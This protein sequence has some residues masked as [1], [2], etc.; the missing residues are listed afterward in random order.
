MAGTNTIRLRAVLDDKV[1]SGLA[2]IADN[3][4][5]LGGKGS[6]ASLF[7]N[8]GARAVAKGFDLIGQAAGRATDIIGDSIQAAAADEASQQRLATALSANVKAWD[9]NTAAIERVITARTKLGFADDDQRDS[10]ATL[11][12][13]THDV[14]KALELQRGAMD[15]ARARHVDLS[16]AS[17]AVAKAFAG[18]TKTLKALL[19]GLKMGAT[20]AETLA[21][22][23]AMANGQAEAFAE[24]NQGKLLKS[25]VA[26]N[27]AMEK[28]GYT[29]LPT[30]ADV[31]DLAARAASGFAAT[32]QMLNP[33]VHKT[34]EESD[35]LFQSMVDGLSGLGPFANWF[36]SV[37]VNIKNFGKEAEIAAVKA[38]MIDRASR[39]M[40]GNIADAVDSTAD[41]V[42]HDA[43]RI[44]DKLSGIP[45]EVV[46]NIRGARTEW[47]DAWDQFRDDLKHPMSEAAEIAKLQGILASKKLAEGL[48]SNDPLVKAE[49]EN[50]RDIARRRLNEL[51]G[52]AYLA[53]KRAGKGLVTGF[54]DGATGAGNVRLSVGFLQAASTRRSHSGRASGGP[55]HAGEAYTVGEDGPETLVMGDRGGYVYNA[56]QTAR[57]M[58]EGPSQPIVIPLYLDGK[59]IAEAIAPHRYREWQRAPAFIGRP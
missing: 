41:S 6:A 15:I 37:A 46:D 56:P 1:S 17:D 29:I 7:G 52:Q 55:V 22:A 54:V 12:G 2:K 32:L 8:V 3:F 43:D 59:K 51:Q 57:I 20:D 9:G 26:V 44:V 36:S 10:L 4:D 50:V 27:E 47:K 18:N 24:T 33:T 21:N 42:A 39:V 16:T 48:R 5:R 49:A 23:F 11:S 58:G 45:S 25:Q 30:V 38:D 34:K 19:P 40:G 13:A 35:D 31:T 14:T 53:G 28:I